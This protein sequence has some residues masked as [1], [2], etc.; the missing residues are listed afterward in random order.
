MKCMICGNETKNM[1]CKACYGE[2][3]SQDK[4]ARSNLKVAVFVI[5]S[6]ILSYII[7]A[8]VFEYV[9]APGQTGLPLWM[10]K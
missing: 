8:I 6:L 1:V 7:Y 4:K 10:T 3:K 9:M 2:E 5:L